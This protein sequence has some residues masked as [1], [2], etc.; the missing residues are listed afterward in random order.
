M[1]KRVR[2]TLPWAV[3][4]CLR[5]TVFSLFLWKSVTFWRPIAWSSSHLCK[6]NLITILLV[7]PHVSSSCRWIGFLVPPSLWCNHWGYYPETWILRSFRGYH[8]VTSLTHCRQDYMAHL[9]LSSGALPGGWLPQLVFYR[10]LEWTGAESFGCNLN[11]KK[12]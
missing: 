4:L 9:L 12:G 2:V 7:E 1:K 8:Q 6:E 3:I 11:E 5:L 10:W